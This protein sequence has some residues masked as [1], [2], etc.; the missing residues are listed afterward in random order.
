MEE[1]QGRAEAMT[2]IKDQ[3]AQ[4]AKWVE[5]RNGPV[6][7]AQPEITYYTWSHS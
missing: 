5:E 7:V 4:F 6:V 3:F 1:S 2:K